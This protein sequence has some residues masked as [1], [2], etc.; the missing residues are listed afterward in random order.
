MPLYNI[1]TAFALSLSCSMCG[2]VWCDHLAVLLFLPFQVLLAHRHL[3][4]RS[5]VYIFCRCGM[6]SAAT[7]NT[8]M[9]QNGNYGEC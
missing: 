1:Y 9:E 2:I 8:R 5:T 3:D 4:L 6:F 7:N